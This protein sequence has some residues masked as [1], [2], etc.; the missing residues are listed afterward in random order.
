MTGDEMRA[1]R[2]RM[3]MSAVEFGRALGYRS[4][5]NTIKV[6]IQRYER[7]KEVP[8]PVVVRVRGLEQART[9]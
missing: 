9:R 5:Y 8:A 6:K 3:G 2:K 7:F 4:S 1:I